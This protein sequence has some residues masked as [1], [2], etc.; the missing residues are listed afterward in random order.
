MNCTAGIVEHVAWTNGSMHDRVQL[1][2]WSVFSIIDL[3][4]FIVSGTVAVLPLSILGIYLLWRPL[5]GQDR[6]EARKN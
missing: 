1:Q 4:L 5:A 3:A 6:H 2:H